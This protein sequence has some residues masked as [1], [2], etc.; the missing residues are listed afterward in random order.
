[1]LEHAERAAQRALGL[2]GRVREVEALLDERDRE[3]LALRDSLRQ[4]I[5]ERNTSA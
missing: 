3:I 5:R 1:V 2:E 4:T